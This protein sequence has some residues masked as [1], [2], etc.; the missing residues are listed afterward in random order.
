MRKVGN[1]LGLCLVLVMA[2]VGPAVG[3]DSPDVSL[4]SRLLAAIRQVE[5][6][7]GRH[8]RGDGGRSLGSY[9]I[10]RAYW[11]D[12]CRQLKRERASHVPWNYDRWVH[13]DAQA[14][15]VM[16]AYWRR[17]AESRY[18]P[19]SMSDC[20]VLARVHN[21]GPRG[22]SKSSTAAYW[23]RVRKVMAE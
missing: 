17:Y 5:S 9:Q 7:G 2:W 14:E 16:K 1:R 20:E 10:S 19:D 18:I 22:Y 21:G 15:R 3:N 12:G 13:N 23:E 8:T 11:A 6:S 4:L